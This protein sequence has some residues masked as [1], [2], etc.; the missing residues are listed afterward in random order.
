MLPA[1]ELPRGGLPCRGRGL[2]DRAGPADVSRINGRATAARHP[3][4]GRLRPETFAH[5]SV[6]SAR[7]PRAV[8]PPPDQSGELACRRC[9]GQGEIASEVATLA[10]SLWLRNAIP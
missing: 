3:K 10:I 6:T 2:Q 4:R 7:E 9:R 1:P 8:S 5:G